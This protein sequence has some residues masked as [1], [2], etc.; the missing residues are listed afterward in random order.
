MY[1]FLNF[2]PHPQPTPLPSLPP[3]PPFSLRWGRNIECPGE[4]PFLSGQYAVNFVQGFEHA[5][6]TPYP[7]QASA[8]CKHFFANSLDG[9]N[10]TDRHH[11]DSYVPQQDIV[12]SYLP[13][14]QSCVEE[15]HVTG[16][17]W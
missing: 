16:I 14:F 13:A 9:W 12:D 11:I 15:G 4:D 3:F 8:C 6:E 1:C 10:G 2:P 17:M 5:K 7:L